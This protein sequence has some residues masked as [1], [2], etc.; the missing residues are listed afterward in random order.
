M[1]V[2]LPAPFS[3]SSAWTSPAAR[4]RSTWSLATTLGKALRMPRIWTS[5]ALVMDGCRRLLL[6]AL[7]ALDQPVHRHDVRD[8]QHLAGRHDLLAALVL[9]RA[10]EH[11]ELAIDDLL[12]ALLNQLLHVVGHL[13]VDRPEADPAILQVAP[14]RLAIVRTRL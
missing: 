10:L 13:G 11:L 7:G 3:P 12:L 2:V 1:S 9:Q 14:V 6:A 8:V 4:A 5:G